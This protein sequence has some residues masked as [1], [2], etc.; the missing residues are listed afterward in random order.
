MAESSKSQNSL[1]G[2][3]GLIFGEQRHRE[4]QWLTHIHTA[5]HD[6]ANSQNPQAESFNI[7]LI[8]SIQMTGN[9]LATGYSQI[10]LL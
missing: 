3:N 10:D 8:A 6:K 2:K 1:F 5:T 9:F 7:L 4:N